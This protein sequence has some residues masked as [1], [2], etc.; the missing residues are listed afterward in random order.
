MAYS[1]GESSFRTPFLS[2]AL[3]RRHLTMPSVWLLILCALT[4]SG[5]GSGYAALTSTTVAP[6]ATEDMVYPCQFDLT[7]SSSTEVQQG[8]LVMY[9]RADTDTLYND[10]AF[11]DVVKTLH[12]SILWAHECNAKSFTDLQANADQGPARMLFTAL[13]QLSDLTGHT[14]LA[15]ARVVLYGFSA[16]GVLTASMVNV[17][18]DRVLGAIQ[19]AAGSTYVNLDSIPA[20][21][22]AVAIPRLILANAADPDSGTSRSY[23][24]FQRGRAQGAP[25][26]YAVQNATGH[27]CNLSTRS[28]V[29]PWLQWVAGAGSVTKATA[30]GGV[31]SGVLS[32]FTCSPNGVKDFQGE[33]DCGISAAKLGPTAAPGSV[34]NG[35]LPDQTTAEAWLAWVTNASTN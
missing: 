7:L 8:V 5:C 12:Y 18:P 28:L 16:A 24:Y 4:V 32:W 3:F 19:Y 13:A 11:R 27:C 30:P 31:S 21:A 26:A 25:W 34:D 29:V 22:A 14:E 20:S 10:P 15:S 33:T 1:E 35:W 17:H 6:L 2:M 23:R 9:A